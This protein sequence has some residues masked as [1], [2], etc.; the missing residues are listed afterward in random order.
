M[1]PYLEKE[2]AVFRNTELRWDHTFKTG[3]NKF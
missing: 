2:M 3:K 1:K